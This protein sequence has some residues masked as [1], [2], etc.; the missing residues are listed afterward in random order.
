MRGTQKRF[1]VSGASSA[2]IVGLDSP[3]LRVAFEA[4]GSPAPF[5]FHSGDIDQYVDM[6]DPFYLGIRA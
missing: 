6:S 3:F 1:G 4:T 2:V 5:H